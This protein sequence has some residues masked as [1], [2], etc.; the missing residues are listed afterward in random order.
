MRVLLVIFVAVIAETT[1]DAEGY[2][3]FE[4][5]DTFD[6]IYNEMDVNND[7]ILS[8]SEV[9]DSIFQDFQEEFTDAPEMSEKLQQILKDSDANKDGTITKPE[10]HSFIQGAQRIVDDMDTDEEE[11]NEETDDEV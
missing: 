7:G 9:W 3:G 1:V 8:E 6:E 2:M 11:S 10:L 4:D 5:D